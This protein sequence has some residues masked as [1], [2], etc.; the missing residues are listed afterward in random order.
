[1]ASADKWVRAS[2]FPTK[3]DDC[4][5]GPKAAGTDQAAQAIR[6]GFDYAQGSTHRNDSLGVHP[7]QTQ[8]RSNAGSRSFGSVLLPLYW[9]VSTVLRY[10]GMITRGSPS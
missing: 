4:S 8:R 7:Q 2:L 5:E 3:I 10:V 1:M 9:R 6:P